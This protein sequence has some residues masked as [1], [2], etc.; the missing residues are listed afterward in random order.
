MV[1]MWGRLNSQRGHRES[2]RDIEGTIRFGG[3]TGL[4]AGVNS[5]GHLCLRVALFFVG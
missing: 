3:H 5:A 2:Q 4:G 1:A